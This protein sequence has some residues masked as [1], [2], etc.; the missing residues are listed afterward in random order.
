[1][2]AYFAAA[3]CS[4]KWVTKRAASG[5]EI[6]RHPGGGDRKFN[7]G[8]SGRKTGAKGLV[9]LAPSVTR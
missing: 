3:S 4:L 8:A 9:G 5:S 7:F 6:R 1:V 2:P